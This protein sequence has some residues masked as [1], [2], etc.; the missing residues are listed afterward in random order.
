MVQN[1]LLKFPF[2]KDNEKKISVDKPGFFKKPGFLVY[3]KIELQETI[4]QGNP[5]CRVVVYLRITKKLKI[6]PEENTLSNHFNRFV[7]S[8]SSRSIPNV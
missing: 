2:V 8:G 1:L 5:G 7:V 4:A 3:G 6:P